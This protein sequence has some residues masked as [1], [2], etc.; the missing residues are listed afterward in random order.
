MEFFFLTFQALSCKT[1]SYIPS[2]LVCCKTLITISLCFSVCSISRDA[3]ILPVEFLEKY[4][5]KSKQ[6]NE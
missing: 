4:D 5:V 3:L 6:Q 1:R 2:E